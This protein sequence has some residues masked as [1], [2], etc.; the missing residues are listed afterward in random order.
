MLLRSAIAC[1][2]GAVDVGMHRLTADPDG[3]V[4]ISS[5][6]GTSVRLKCRHEDTSD[7]QMGQ[8]CLR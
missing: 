6:P 5:G 2:R 7:E 4:W 8:A 1:T 3:D